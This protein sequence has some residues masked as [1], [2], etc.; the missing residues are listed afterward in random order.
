MF[1]YSLQV[2]LLLFAGAISL[3]AQPA[4]QPLIAADRALLEATAG[5]KPNLQ[6]YELALAADYTEVESGALHSRKEVLE[7][8]NIIR[9]FSFGYE[10]PQAVLLTPSSGYVIAEVSYAGVMNGN[11]FRGRI[12]STTVFSIEH[13]QWLA[14]LRFAEPLRP[15]TKPVASAPDHDP[16]LVALRS[17][18]AQVEEKAL[19]H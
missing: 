12:L 13:G 15:A 8:M 6:K 14:H 19:L 18:A 11:Y 4:I 17:L 3:R 10:N 9:D 5:P 7:Q 2:F 1:R 16:T